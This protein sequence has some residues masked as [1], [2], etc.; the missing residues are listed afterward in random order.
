MDLGVIKEI[1]MTVTPVIAVF[2][3]LAGLNT[4]RR[5]LRGSHDFELSRR[6]LL[7]A[8]GCRDALRA[9][10]NPFLQVGEAE[11]G[12]KDWEVSA[13]ERRWALVA[14]AM[15]ELRAAVLESEVSWGE[16]F[17]NETKELNTLAVRLSISIRHYLSS[18]E[19]GPSSRLFS[20]KD[21]AILWGDDEDEYGLGLNDVISRFEQK[22]KPKLDRK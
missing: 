1:I 2:I 11:R 6:L 16:G 12:R 22:V 8:Y 9:A 18:Q 14:E 10:R 7:S 5:S 15:T 19:K 13:Y 3:A 4:W 20:D 17:Q 21:E